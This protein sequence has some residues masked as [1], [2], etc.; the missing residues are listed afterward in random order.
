MHRGGPLDRP[1]H[2]L[3]AR[4][5]ADCAERVLPL[6]ERASARAEPRRAIETG[7]RWATGAIP[8]GDAQKASVAAHA[9]A[10]AMTDPAAC[11]A[12]RA[13]GHAAAT[14]HFA[15]HALGGAL[16]ALKAID[17]AGGDL[18]A[19]HR[20]QVRRLPAA[21]REIGRTGLAAKLPRRLR[22]QLG[23]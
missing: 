6:F 16:Y 2:Y 15:E 7:R 21:V 14:A 8:V 5:A 23:L 17:A 13:A 22:E 1:R 4:W 20:W 12:A 9:A 19:E 3:L 18:R 10:R 11:A